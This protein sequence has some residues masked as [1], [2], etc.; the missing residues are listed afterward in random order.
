M[1]IGYH[2]NWPSSSGAHRWIYDAWRAGFMELNHDVFPISNLDGFP[3]PKLLPKLDIFLTDRFLT[4]LRCL[5]L[6]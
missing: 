1:R 3:E 6:A 5:E 2:V 4:F